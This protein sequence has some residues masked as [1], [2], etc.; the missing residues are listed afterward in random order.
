V[1][2]Q[3]PFEV[4]AGQTLRRA[5]ATST[6][7]RFET[8]LIPSIPIAP[9]G[10]CGWTCK[11]NHFQ[12]LP[13]WR[14]GRGYCQGGAGGKE[15]SER[16]SEDLGLTGDS[17]ALIKS[18]HGAHSRRWWHSSDNPLLM[19]GRESDPIHLGSREAALSRAELTNR[20]VPDFPDRQ[21]LYLYEF[22]LRPA[23]VIS[24]CSYV[25]HPSDRDHTVMLPTAEY[26]EVV[27]YVN[28]QEMPGSI[29]LLTLKTNLILVDLIT[30]EP[31][32]PPPIEVA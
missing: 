24:P 17:I 12:P 29:S 26:G 3:S 15:C 11:A 1:K 13:A 25:E 19:E 27:R 28:F 5:V 10:S 21:Y 8:E 30:I 9:A 18:L 4:P 2:V 14:G 32:F 22:K 6:P 20:S 23:A 7:D 16:L 31:T